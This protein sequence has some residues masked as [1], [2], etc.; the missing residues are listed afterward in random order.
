MGWTIDTKKQFAPRI[1]ITYQ[2]D[3]KTVIR[4]G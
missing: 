1:G 3:P 2:I 4:T